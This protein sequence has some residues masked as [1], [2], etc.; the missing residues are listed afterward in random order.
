MYYKENL[1]LVFLIASKDSEL[2]RNQYL[3]LLLLTDIAL[4]KNK[5]RWLAEMPK[6]PFCAAALNP[7]TVYPPKLS[8]IADFERCAAVAWLR[9]RESAQ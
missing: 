1:L 3:Q 2:T 5:Q 9:E 7:K 8:W 4:E 6:A